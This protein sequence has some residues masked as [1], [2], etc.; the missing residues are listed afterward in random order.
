MNLPKSLHG[1]GAGFCYWCQ[2]LLSDPCTKKQARDCPNGSY[3]QS[4]GVVLPK[5]KLLS[6]RKGA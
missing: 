2:S 3:E 1:K 4:M 5:D 6:K